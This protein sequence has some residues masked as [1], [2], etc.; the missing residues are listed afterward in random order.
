M[1]KAQ[2]VECISSATQFDAND[3]EQVVNAFV[4]VVKDTL[5]RGG[6]VNIIGFGKWEVR[7]RKSRNSY[8]PHTRKKMTVPATTVPVFKAGKS[9]KMAVK[10]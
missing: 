4:N 10:N 2:L 5:S 1:N 8:N 3:C 6:N 9:L 7:K